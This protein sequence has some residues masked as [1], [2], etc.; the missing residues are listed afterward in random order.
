MKIPVK[1]IV[2]GL[3]IFLIGIIFIYYG[4]RAFFLIEIN[5]ISKMTIN[6]YK[7]DRIEAMIKFLGSEEEELRHKN[8]VIWALGKLE[9]KRA[10]AV[11]RR[12]YT[13]KECDHKK[14][15]CQYELKKAISR[16]EGS[17][18]DLFTYKLSK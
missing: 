18:M 11:L 14:Y 12:L 2:F 16:L 1:K 8:R 13:G 10:L 3:L 15:V 17:R 6:K 5:S 7:G 9:D 4:L